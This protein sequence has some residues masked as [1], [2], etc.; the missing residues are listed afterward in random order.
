MG[1]VSKK[2]NIFE[3]E[4]FEVGYWTNNSPVNTSNFWD[5]DLMPHNHSWTGAPFG[6]S[7]QN[8]NITTNE[9][10][11]VQNIL[12]KEMHDSILQIKN[13]LQDPWQKFENDMQKIIQGHLI[14]IHLKIIIKTGQ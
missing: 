14:Q 9:D 7:G 13:S 8:L 6:Y 2:M 12:T 10:I 3:K 1:H 11:S 5:E 4:F